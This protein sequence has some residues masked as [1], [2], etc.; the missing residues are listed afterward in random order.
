MPFKSEAQR[1]F[2]WAKHP[3]IARKWAH[4]AGE[5]RS[6][7]RQ[8]GEK[9]RVM[10][11]GRKSKTSLRG[12]I[13]KGTG[14]A[15]IAES[16]GGRKALKTWRSLSKTSRRFLKGSQFSSDLTGYLKGVRQERMERGASA[17]S[18]KSP[19]AKRVIIAQTKKLTRRRVAAESPPAVKTRA[20]AA[21]Y[22]ARMKKMGR[23]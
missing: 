12:P 8:T 16:G 18:G 5:T 2:M 1:K 20:G 15:L 17:V 9:D 13:K 6:P 21:A 4:E 10:P 23:I 7:G 11:Q 22:K 3:K 14:K 19:A